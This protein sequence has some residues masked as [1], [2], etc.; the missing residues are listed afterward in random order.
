MPRSRTAYAVV[1]CSRKPC[2][3]ENI[4]GRHSGRDHSIVVTLTCCLIF[5]GTRP[6]R[7]R[8]S[9]LSRRTGSVTAHIQI[10]CSTRMRHSRVHT[11]FSN[12]ILRRCSSKTG[13]HLV[14]LRVRGGSRL[15]TG[16]IFTTESRNTIKTSRWHYLNARRRWGRRKAPSKRDAQTATGACD[17]LRPCSPSC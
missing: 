8:G 11:R 12:L 5:H 3:P 1:E 10:V 6:C 16:C 7:Y 17:E 9:H 4:P 13:F 14:K 2:W 15:T